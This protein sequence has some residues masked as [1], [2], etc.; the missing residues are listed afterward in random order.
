MNGQNSLH[1][2][3]GPFSCTYSPALPEML[4]QMN[5]TL[6]ISTYQ[7]GK[8]IFI[9]ARD[10][11]SLV[12]LPRNFN[13]AMAMGISGNMLAIAAR[14][15]VIV[16][17]H[18]PG[19]APAYP[20]QP[21]TYDS[22]YVPRATY[23]T[24]AVDIHGLE[25]GREGLWAVNTSFSCLCILDNRYSFIPKWKPS[26]ITGMAS[27][28]RCHLNGVAMKDGAP[29]YVTTMGHDDSH[30]SWRQTLPNGG[31]FI[32]VPSN[33]IIL[34]GLPMPHS[35][36]LF[37][38]KLYML[39]SATGEIVCVDVEKRQYDVV[40]KIEGFVRGMAR[41]GDH[42]FVAHSRLRQNS[43]TFK[44]LPIAKKA[45][46]SGVTIFHLP[47]GARVAELK[48]LSTVDE[49]FDVQIIPGLKRPGIVSPANE[50]HRLSLV[51][52]GSSFWARPE[53]KEGPVSQ[54]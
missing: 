6:A 26:F 37:D 46:S 1:Q 43:S 34:E 16:L 11:E 22:L 47:T 2:S 12:Q 50:V 53:K 28:D 23:Y 10:S 32:H 21:Q 41:H 39:F 48:Y 9:S 13:N 42:L 18:E 24:G 27:E 33:E 35:P 45:V 25:W 14:H 51:I 44:D 49:I 7:A 52:P 3:S 29:L 38:N 40:N 20:K 15:E 4:I 54:D 5:C 17:A 19:L 31:M 8:V 36:R 30:Q